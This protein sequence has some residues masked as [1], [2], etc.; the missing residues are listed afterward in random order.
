MWKNN[1][2][3]RNF[4]G[5]L[6]LLVVTAFIALP[7]SFSWR[8][9]SQTIN[10]DK[11]II[12][13][14]LF[15]KTYSLNL[16]LKKGLD[17]AGGIQLVMRADVSAIDQ[18]DRSDALKSAVEIIRNRVDAY[19]VAEPLIQTAVSGDDYQIIV[20][21]PG[22]TDIDQAVALIGTTAMMDFRLQEATVAAAWQNTPV[23]TTAATSY[24]QYYDYLASFVPT[25]LT[26]EMLD[27][28]TATFD[29]QT[30][31]PVVALQFTTEGREK[32]AEITRNNQGNILG[33]FIDDAPI[34]LPKINDPIL[35]GNAII[36][37]GFTVKESQ[38]LAVQLNSGAL[39]VPIEIVQQRQVG[40][41]LGEDSVAKS[42]FAGIVGLLLVM[43]FMVLNYG[44]KGLIADFGLV[45]Y[46]V[47]MLAIYK[48]FGITMSLPSIAAFLI[49][50]GMAVDSNILIFSRLQEELQQGKS[51]S[52]AR[53]ASFGKAWDSIRDANT[54]T[55][56]IA[57]ILINPL[58]FSILNSNGMIRGFGITLLLGVITGLFTGVFVSRNLLRIFLREREE[59]L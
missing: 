40:A 1:K 4:V 52:A 21:V 47:L 8:V 28:A 19:G 34:T 46:T 16:P 15:G 54:I 3:I 37:G 23:A 30:R 13:P 42:L 44:Q 32:F 58:N 39:P 31:Q 38:S 27:K 25:E 26:G 45:I 14:T 43:L 2:L 50:I 24:Q 59:K 5:I 41:T 22:L 29:S 6:A 35:D 18:A 10:F 17:I 9:G 7:S 48:L 57:I 56:M 49:S 53:E 36:S 55:I 33:I 11:N 12:Q 20:E 51:L